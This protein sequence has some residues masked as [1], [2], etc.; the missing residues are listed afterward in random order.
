MNT[1]TFS[2]ASH[3]QP[4]RSSLSWALTAGV[5][6]GFTPLLGAGEEAQAL[7]RIWNDVMESPETAQPQWVETA[8]FFQLLINTT[9]EK[10]EAKSAP[11]Q[12]VE[13][14]YLLVAHR[15]LE[16]AV[17]LLFERV[18]DLLL[19]GRMN[20]C[21]AILRTIDIDQLDSNLMVSLLSITLPAASELPYRPTLVARVE[22]S[23]MK[24]DPERT[25]GLLRG[26]R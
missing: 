4:P 15:E 12:W 14:M 11:P 16:R 1:N 18:D 21:D 6:V 26:L 7:E 9:A 19:E 17:D 25:A 23:F 13:E 2:T 8:D 3:L 22:S 20:E 10:R 24:T 5:Y